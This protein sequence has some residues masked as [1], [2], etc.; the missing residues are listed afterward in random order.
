MRFYE[1]PQSAAC[2]VHD[3]H[4]QVLSVTVAVTHPAY[5][6]LSPGDQKSP[7]S[8]NRLNRTAVTAQ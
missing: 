7:G 4:R 6:L 5:V 1:D 2:M 8:Q 3:P